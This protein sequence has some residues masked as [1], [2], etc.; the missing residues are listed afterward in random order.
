M[1]GLFHSMGGRFFNLQ[2]SKQKLPSYAHSLR[3]LTLCVSLFAASNVARAQDIS[4]SA[5]NESLELVIKKLR[6]QTDYV[7]MAPSSTLAKTRPVT[8]N[9][10]GVS[11]DQAMREIFKNQPDNLDYEIKGKNIIIRQRSEPNLNKTKEEQPSKKSGRVLDQ[12]GNPIAGAT[13]TSSKGGISTSSSGSGSFEIA[14]QDGDHVTIKMLGY[15]PQEIE[16][17]GNIGEIRLTPSNIVMETAEVINT[18]YQSIPKER[19]IGSF[20]QVDNKLLNRSVST[21]ILDRLNGIVPGLAFQSNDLVGNRIQANPNLRRSP[22]TIRGESSF[23]ASTSPLLVV[24]NFPFEGDLSSINPN[25]IESITVLKD[26]SA[27]S[28][29]GARSGNGVIIITTKKGQLNEKIK[30]DFSANLSVSEK[31]DLFYDKHFLDAKSFIE[32]EQYLFDQGYFN[33]DI[34]NKSTRPVVSP[35]VQIFND[36]KTGVISAEQGKQQ[37]DILRNKDIRNDLKKYVYQQAIKQQYSMAFS[38]GT[39]KFNYRLSTGYDKN[40]EELIRNGF[41][42]FTVNSLNTYTPIKNLDITTG[43]NYTQ[44]KTA[45]NNEWNTYSIANSK[46]S[47]ITLFPYSQL[48]DTEGNSVAALTRLSET[49]LDEAEAKGYRDWRYRPIDE[50]QLADNTTKI[51]S[52]LARVSASYKILPSLSASIH[53]Q[54][55]QQ[56]ITTRRYRN[57]DSYYVRDLYNK[58]SIYDSGKK[59]F[60]Y[61]YPAGGNL[62]Q[63]NTDWKSMNF[64]MQVNFD[65]EFEKHA[66]YA[67]AG[68]EAREL[69]TDG[70]S[71][72]LIGY[73]DQFGT[74]NMSLD[75]TK[76]FSTSPSGSSRLPGPG[77]SI[78]GTINR[79]LSYYANASYTYSNKYILTGSARTDGA[80]IFGVNAN[81]RFSPLWSLGA[82]WEISKESFYKLDAMPYLKARISF[83]Y[84][85]NTYQNGSGY[86]TGKY[87]TNFL[88]AQSLVSLTA[89]N[90]Q[91]RW[92]KVRNLNMGLDFR[93]KGNILQGS[94]EYFNK[95]GLDLVQPTDLAPQTGFTTYYG[96]TGQINTKGFDVNITAKILDSDFKW[97][98]TALYSFIKDKIVKYDP[99][100]SSISTMGGVEGKPLRAIFSYKWAGLNPENGNPVGFVNG[101]RSEDYATIYSNLNESDLVYSG[102]FTPTSFGAL[103]ND[104][105]YKN[106]DLSVNITYFFDF[107]FRKPTTATNYTD[108]LTTAGY[109]DFG[110][111]WQ[112][113]GDEAFTNVPS[114]SYPS[115]AYRD[116]FYQ[117]SEVKIAKGD[118]IRLRDIRLS[119]DF[120]DL[121]SNKKINLNGFLY[122]QNLAIIWRKNKDGIDPQMVSGRYPDPKMFAI[123]INA[124][125]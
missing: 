121:W 106:F 105:S 32:V 66:I 14:V 54:T 119:Y 33:S 98:T 61:N 87:T 18:G 120:S 59:T 78:S 5:K 117:F 74:A 109:S 30:I 13:V 46:Y 57:P 31:P 112:K 90:S 65:K 3:V 20:V 27:A 69:K 84:N 122:G 26:A 85:G 77:S 99:P 50:I 71:L 97:N 75:Y 72:S 108:Q 67:L 55:E 88:G 7:I 58:F 40:R 16:V 68:Y 94:I 17:R 70:S 56:K 28:I 116:W 102:N 124:K 62:D 47:G 42:R 24:D 89:P 39:K 36:L 51:N 34:S 21:N 44:S 86:L 123:G 48:V 35:A 110:N 22:I 15:E 41:N 49:Y 25:D 60:T 64:R 37:L 96:N 6:A 101:Q 63:T 95:T 107:V 8:V 114:M 2:E 23:Y 52:I 100:R 45:L 76:S 12:T 92:E 111:R 115:D 43:I 29:W 91:L 53:Y 103:R 83:G 4:L 82:G 19:A 11:I 1:N 38:G 80:N 9:L 125:F 113:P 81:N 93:S 10:K 79:Y 104:F 118:H 73:D